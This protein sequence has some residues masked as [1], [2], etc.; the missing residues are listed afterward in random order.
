MTWHLRFQM[1]DDGSWTYHA[2][3][4]G[5][6]T[7]CGATPTEAADTHEHEDALRVLLGQRSRGAGTWCPVCAAA[8]AA[9]WADTSAAH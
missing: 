9:R 8:I 2:G 4:V 3:R 5:F 6:V 7:D 1:H